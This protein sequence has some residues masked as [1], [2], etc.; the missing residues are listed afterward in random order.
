MQQNINLHCLIIRKNKNTGDIQMKKRFFVSLF[1]V[2]AMVTSL[3]ALNA[4]TQPAEPQNMT[5]LN[6]SLNPEVEFVLDNENKVVSVNA[7]NEDGNVIISA[8]AF[9]NVVGLSAPEAVKLFVDVSAETGFLLEG[10][11]KAGEN[12]IGISI[13]GDAKLAEDLYKSVKKEV[14]DFISENNLE[15]S[16]T[17]LVT[18]SKEQLEKLLAECAPYLDKA[19]IQAM[20]QVEIIKNIAKSRKETANLYSQELK[21]AFYEMQEFAYEQTELE[22]LKSKLSDLGKMAIETVNKTYTDAVAKLASTRIALLVQAES[23]YQKALASYRQAKA[24]YLNFRNYI[25]TLDQTAITEA[26]NNQL[27][28]LEGLLET[29]QTALVAAGESANQAIEI[30]QNTLKAA[31]DAVIALIETFSVKASDFAL[32]ISLAT[33]IAIESINAEFEQGYAQFVTA[34]NNGLNEMK[35]ALEQGYVAQ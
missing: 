23:I 12:E 14:E 28:L 24:D 1:L 6:V 32:E 22:I 4:C 27:D 30:A 34:V 19:K 8:T 26:I 13:S 35:N 17:E 21:K 25:A 3:F 29:A 2:V 20:E 31:H 5:V 7:L 15:A 33:T 11:L 9:A 16:V 18:V 10:N